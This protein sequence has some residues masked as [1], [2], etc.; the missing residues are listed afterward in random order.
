MTNKKM[1]QTIQTNL[2]TK[3]IALDC[4]FVGH[5]MD[6]KREDILARVSVVN[7]TGQTILD[8]FVIPTK[9]VADYRT[10]R[11]GVRPEDIGSGSGALEFAVV[12]GMVICH[13][14]FVKF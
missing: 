1:I 5:T 13:H 12:Q 4:E 10:A 8:T 14:S 3:Q 2:L 7:F 11:S 6:S 9:S